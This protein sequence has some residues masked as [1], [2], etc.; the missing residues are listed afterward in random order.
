VHTGAL[1]NRYFT[2]AGRSNRE[3]YY[4]DFLANSVIAGAGGALTWLLVQAGGLRIVLS[5][6]LTTTEGLYLIAAAVGVALL[7]VAAVLVTC[8]AVRRLHDLNSS[9][10]LCLLFLIPGV[11]LILQLVLLL[12]EGAD[13]PNRYGPDPS[14]IYRS[15]WS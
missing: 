15:F 3:L 14:K 2:T 10:W 9:G 7:V 4:L 8:A 12:A 1:D 5:E 13:G 6:G 11:N